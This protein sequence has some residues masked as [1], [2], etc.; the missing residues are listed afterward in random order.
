MRTLFSVFF[1]LLAAAA[2]AQSTWLEAECGSVGSLWNRTTD[3]SV[4]NS[5][6][7]TIQAGQNSTASAP[8]NT[9]GHI[10]LPFSTTQ[11]GTYRVFARMLGPN[12]NDDS[13]WVSMDG[14]AWVMWNNWWNTAWIWAQ[15]PNTF[16][17]SAGSH[18]LTIA[19][20]E[21]GARLDKVNITTSTALPTGLGS[22]ASNCSVGTTLSVAPTTVSLAAAAN[23]TGTFSITSNTSWTVTDDQA[24]LTVSPAS[25]ANN[26]AITVMAQQNTGSA[27]RTATVTAAATGVPSQTVTVTQSGTGGG[28]TCTL[29]PV[30]TFASLPNISFLPDPFTFMNGTR[31][32]TRA[33]WTCRRA[34]IAAQAQEFEYGYKPNTPSSATTGSRSGNTV[35]VNVADNGRTLTFNASIT[36]PSTGSAPYPAIIGIGA[37]NLNNSALS[38][39]GVAVINFPNDQI[40]QQN[41]QGSRGVGR[42]YD[43]YGNGHSAGALMAWAWGVSRLIDALEKTPAANIDTTRLG[44]TGC[45]RNG[46]GAL[47]AGA[48]DERIKLTIPQEPG[49]GGS[50]TWR[51]SN[52]MLSQGQ[53][54]QTLGQI[55]GENV[56]FRSNFSQFSS[57]VPKLPFDHHSIEGLVAPRALLVIENNILWL[58]PQSSWTG[59][60]A[61]RR[62]WDALGIPDR[63]GYSLTTE[64]GHCSFPSSQQAEV[65]AYVQKF[66]VGGGTGNTNIMRNDPGVPFNQGM[67][68]NWTTPALQ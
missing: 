57:T 47:A 11:S 62:I 38:S 26:G 3:A 30:P 2:N 58:G 44:V 16:N 25:G 51:V 42:F 33:E 60:N 41:G 66:L 53:N 64:H 37:S 1:L 59:A 27:A 68:I 54:T 46:K 17:L 4:S 6:Y 50:G 61:A 31:M 35:T 22:P 39:Q 10:S 36:Y 29:P 13:F 34:E 48:F 15:F 19:F 56:W 49:S 9:A 5:Q 20:R 12:A 24:W 52:S 63:M 14:G 23:S 45:S 32:T 28:T 18:T 8:A 65:N 67:W 43:M 21:D 55:V 7:V 40:A